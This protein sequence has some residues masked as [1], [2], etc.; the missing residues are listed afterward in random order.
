MYFTT[1]SRQF[2]AIL[3]QYQNLF[4]VYASRIFIVTS[5][6]WQ[7][8]PSDVGKWL[9]WSLQHYQIPKHEL[10]TLRYMDGVSLAQLSEDQFKQY[11]TEPGYAVTLHAELDIWKDGN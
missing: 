5:D 4:K 7:W 2:T 9:D 6:P 10:A 11:T 1:I 8:S 3:R